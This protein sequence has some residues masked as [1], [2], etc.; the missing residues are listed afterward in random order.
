MQYATLWVCPECSAVVATDATLDTSP[1]SC[2]S[3]GHSGHFLNP[4]LA[5]AEEEAA[6]KQELSASGAG[7]GDRR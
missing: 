4:R 1:T 2:D 5:R 7:P 6:A 3:C